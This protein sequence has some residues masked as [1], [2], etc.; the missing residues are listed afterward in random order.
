MVHLMEGHSQFLLVNIIYIKCNLINPLK[1]RYVTY[2]QIFSEKYAPK[3]IMW[4]NIIWNFFF[5]L[6]NQKISAI[7]AQLEVLKV[8]FCNLRINNI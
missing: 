1:L 6:N 7:S 5:F 2:V 8:I 3:C 4:N